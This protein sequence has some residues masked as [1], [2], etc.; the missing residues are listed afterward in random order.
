MKHIVYLFVI[1]SIFMLYLYS[2]QLLFNSID[3]FRDFDMIYY[4]N[5]EHRKDRKKQIEKTL[6]NLSISTNKIHR[7]NA[8]YEKLNGH[9]GCALSHISALEDAVIKNYS[10][11]IILED[12]AFIRNKNGIISFHNILNHLKSDWD[13]ILLGGIEY[14]TKKYNKDAKRCNH[15]TTTISYCIQRKYIQT[16]LSNFKKSAELMKKEMNILNNRNYSMKNRKVFETKF[17]IDQRWCDLQKKDKWYIINPH[18]FSQGRL[19]SD[20]MKNIYI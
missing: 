15:V 7:I 14:D 6:N 13:I 12:D 20:I 2:K 18:L 3:P 1:L 16:L 11:I 19:S 9:L 10:K 8:Y 5:L 17:A 4:I